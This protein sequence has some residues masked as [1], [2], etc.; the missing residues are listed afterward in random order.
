MKLRKRCGKKQQKLRW[1][2]G[3]EGRGSNSSLSE[4]DRVQSNL[5]KYVS[6]DTCMYIGVGHVCKWVCDSPFLK[7]SSPCFMFWF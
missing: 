1:Q 7:T 6:M 2:E 4:H 5:V 3:Q